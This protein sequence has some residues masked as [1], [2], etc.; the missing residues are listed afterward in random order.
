MNPIER[1]LVANRGEIAVRIIR[2]AKKMGIQT[3]AVFSEA[4]RSAPHVDMADAAECIGKAPVDQSY[5]NQKKILQAA[6]IHNVD[7]IH[8]GYGLLSEDANFAE[9]CKK[10]GIIFIGPSPVHLREF[11]LKHRARAIAADAGVPL[12][13]GSELI[14]DLDTAEHKAK[15]I[16]Y[17]IM[18]KGT[19]GGGGI[20]MALCKTPDELNENFDRVRRLAES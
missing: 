16:G 17:P 7:A 4:D 14:H 20:G 9:A 8:P 12:A 15:S 1:L 10:H 2:T 19:A 5:L 11:G 3:V 18:L 13:P 6:K